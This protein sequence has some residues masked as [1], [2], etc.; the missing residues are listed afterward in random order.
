MNIWNYKKI[1]LHE[2]FALST[3]HLSDSPQPILL[4]VF[5]ISWPYCLSVESAFIIHNGLV[6]ITDS[7]LPM[8]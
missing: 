4:Y 3:Q 2:K 5:S 8:T 7:S 6:E 1:L